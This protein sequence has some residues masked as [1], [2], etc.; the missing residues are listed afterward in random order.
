MS[1]SLYIVCIVV[2][3][4]SLGIPSYIGNRR[5]GEDT[6]GKTEAIQNAQAVQALHHTLVKAPK[7]VNHEKCTL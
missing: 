3:I 4:N 1:N 2:K 7:C 5:E 6:I